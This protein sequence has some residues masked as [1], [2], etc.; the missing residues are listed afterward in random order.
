MS[1]ACFFRFVAD[2]VG[3][4]P[5]EIGFIDDAE[6]NI[7]AAT[8]FGWK[9]LHWTPA[10]ALADAIAAFTHNAQATRL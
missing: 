7:A 4:A 2:G 1:M 6:E 9:A 5:Q 10:S 8:Q 3:L